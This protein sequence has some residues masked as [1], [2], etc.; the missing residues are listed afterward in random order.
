[1]T[2]LFITKFILTLHITLLIRLYS[3]SAPH[4]SL[5]KHKSSWRIIQQDN[6]QQFSVSEYTDL[7]LMYLQSIKDT[8]LFFLT[9][10]KFSPVEFL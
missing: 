10:K 7:G 6:T 8:F 2:E 3:T 1:M 5:H 9:L 4:T